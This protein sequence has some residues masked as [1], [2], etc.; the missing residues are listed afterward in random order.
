MNQKGNLSFVF[1]LILFILTATIMFVLFAPMG[2]MFTVEAYKMS[3]KL[4]NDSNETAETFTDPAMRDQVQ[5]ILQQQKDN[6]V[7]QIDLLGALN[8]YSAIIVIILGTIAL[9]LL[10]RSVVQRNAGVV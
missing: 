5:G 8:K 1:F 9:V 3:E 7:F 6:F 2:Q 10:T 4:V